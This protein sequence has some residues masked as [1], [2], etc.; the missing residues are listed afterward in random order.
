[1]KDLE[2]T[3][4][5]CGD[6]ITL[7]LPKEEYEHYKISGSLF[8]NSKTYEKLFNGYGWVLQQAPFCEVCKYSH[9]IVYM[10]D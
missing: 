3:C 10:E 8:E 9:S 4:S 6:S 2:I 5:N 7:N 1:M